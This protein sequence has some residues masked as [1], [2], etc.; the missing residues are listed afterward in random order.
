MTIL[1]LHLDIQPQ[2]SDDLH[3]SWLLFILQTK[4]SPNLSFVTWALIDLSILIEIA[5]F[6]APRI[7]ATPLIVLISH[8]RLG[9]SSDQLFLTKTHSIPARIV[10]SVAM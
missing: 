7:A 9:S 4:P 5:H 8:H 3:H 2:P 6:I 10:L 1:T